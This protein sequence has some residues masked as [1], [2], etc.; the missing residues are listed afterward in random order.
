MRTIIHT[1][2]NS[3]PQFADMQYGVTALRHT[4]GVSDP[5][6]TRSEIQQLFSEELRIANSPW[7]K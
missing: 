5:R 4:S 2:F 7:A 3:I 6:L 1:I